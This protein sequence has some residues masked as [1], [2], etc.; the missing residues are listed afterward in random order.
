MMAHFSAA[1]AYR[2]KNLS[3]KDKGKDEVLRKL[4][5]LTL[6]TYLIYPSNLLYMKSSASLCVSLSLSCVCVC[7]ILKD[8]HM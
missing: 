7:Y 1:W 3:D 6:K 4:V 5:R 2:Y 8:V